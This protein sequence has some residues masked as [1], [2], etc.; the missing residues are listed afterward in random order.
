LLSSTITSE[1]ERECYCKAVTKIVL[2]FLL[3]LIAYLLIAS[4]SDER[5][6]AELRIGRTESEVIR[7]LGQPSKETTQPEDIKLLVGGRTECG[8][9]VVKLS[10]YKRRLREDIVVAFD[11]SAKVSCIVRTT[12]VDVTTVN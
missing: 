9:D 11:S 3:A 8:H 12:V 4:C 1:I 6:L 7:V 5:L 2:Q 10:I